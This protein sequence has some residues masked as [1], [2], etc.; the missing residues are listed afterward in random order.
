MALLRPM[1]DDEYAAFQ[2]VLRDEYVR[3]M[4]E[5]GF[6][7]KEAA[8]AKADADLAAQLP[9]GLRTAN[10]YVYAIQDE[11][12]AKVG[13]AVVGKRVDQEGEEV[14][15]VY[16]IWLDERA[17]G[18]GYGR[19]AMVELEGE[20]GR[21]GLDRMRLNVFGHNARARQLYRSLGYDELSILMGKRLEV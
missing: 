15:F 20:V 19:A 4:V 13:H 7:S 3:D 10:T 16:D 11:K 2:H 9:D 14:A 12:G 18:R 17:R 8:E 5:S 1:Q 6:M 21:L